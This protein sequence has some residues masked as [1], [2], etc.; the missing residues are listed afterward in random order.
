[1]RQKILRSNLILALFSF[2]LIIAALSCK[3]DKLTEPPQD[4]EEISIPS[5]TQFIVERI[6]TFDNQLRQ[7]KQGAYKGVEYTSIDSAMWNIESLFNVNY[8]FPDLM[9]ESKVSQELNFSI[10]VYDNMLSMHDVHR[11]Y[12]EIVSSVRL[13]YM[14]D[15]FTNN[16]SLM[17]IIVRKGEVVSNKLNV[18]VTLISGRKS[19]DPIEPNPVLNGP[20]KEGDCFYF[21][22]YGGACDDPTWI[23][24]AAE[25]LEDTIN[26]YY[27]WYPKEPDPVRAIYVN[28]GQIFLSGN[29]YFNQNQNSYYIFY[30]LDPPDS[31]L[32]LDYE[33]LNRYYNNE[34]KV[35]FDLVPNDPK[36]ISQLPEDARFMEVEISGISYYIDNKT[37]YAHQNIILYG[38][39]HVIFEYDLCQPRDILNE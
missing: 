25:V 5:K 13:A 9:Y 14:N 29:E 2:A 34:L 23:T 32:Y 26:Y 1:M 8:S 19:S 16:K 4:N 38:S 36:Y 33:L 17:T 21:G 3:K 22:E 28:V 24:D 31:L 12:E 10:N 20:F 39:R 37:L 35:I 27:G 18:N 15:G 6:K 30:H 7:I 11:L